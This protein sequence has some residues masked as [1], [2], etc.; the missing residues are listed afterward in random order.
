M[1]RHLVETL[2]GLGTVHAQ[3]ELLRTTRYELSLWLEDQPGQ[4]SAPVTDIGGHI[5]ITGIA[6]A[7]VLAGPDTLTL[8]LEDGRCLAFQ[9]TNT[10]GGIKSRGWLP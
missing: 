8:T 1:A 4:G 2:T 7:V 5:D 3:G 9:L 10:L 6:E